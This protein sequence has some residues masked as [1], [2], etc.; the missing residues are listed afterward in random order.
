MPLDSL[1]KS[2]LEAEDPI[3]YAFDDLLAINVE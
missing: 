2:T 1:L 3:L